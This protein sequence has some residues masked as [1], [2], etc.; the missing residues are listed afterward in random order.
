[1]NEAKSKKDK[2]VFDDQE[3]NAKRSNQQ[4]EESE[5]LQLINSGLASSDLP[6]MMGQPDNLQLVQFGQ[7]I[8]ENMSRLKDHEKAAVTNPFAQN[9]SGTLVLNTQDLSQEIMSIQAGRRSFSSRENSPEI[10]E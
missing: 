1:M 6:T 5:T 4:P 10:E 8:N 2:I 9:A 7:L 3:A